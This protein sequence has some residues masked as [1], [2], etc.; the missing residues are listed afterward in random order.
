M[1]VLLLE[2]VPHG[3]SYFG[4]RNNLQTC[5]KGKTQTQDIMQNFNFF[6]GKKMF[7]CSQNEKI[8]Q[9]LNMIT[10]KQMPMLLL[11]SHLVGLKHCNKVGGL[12]LLGY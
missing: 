5:N 2:H 3:S 7:L 6:F 9:Q 1:S 10:V 12:D 11:S 8:K 4:L